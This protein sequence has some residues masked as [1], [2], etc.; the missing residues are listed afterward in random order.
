MQTQ[1]DQL[2]LVETS[3]IAKTVDCHSLQL[4]LVA[5]QK[6]VVAQT[7]ARNT[8]ESALAASQAELQHTQ[9]LHQV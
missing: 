1:A 4:H 7:G 2:N 9:A 8:A 6:Q 3:L 5:S